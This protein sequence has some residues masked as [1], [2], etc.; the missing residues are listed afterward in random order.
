MTP[1]EWLVSLHGTTK[2]AQARRAGITKVLAGNVSGVSN[3]YCAWA[4][5]SRRHIEKKL[6][7]RFDSVECSSGGRT[8]HNRMCLGLPKDHHYDALCVGAIPETGYK[9]LT[10]GYFFYVKAMGRGSRFRGKI[11]RCGIITTKLRKGPKR[12]FGFQN[13]DIVR[14]VNPS[15]KYAGRHVGRVITRASGYFDIRKSDNSLVTA[16]H[17]NCTILQRDNGYLCSY[18]K[19]A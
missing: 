14:A 13:G 5:S 10:H 1:Q 15:G 12:R 7:E 6:F 9:D 3:R 2:L 11:N 8:K 18:R 19:G 17:S 16:K 4:S